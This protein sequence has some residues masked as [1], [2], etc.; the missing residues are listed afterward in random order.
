MKWNGVDVT[1]VGISA[2]GFRG[3]TESAPDV[4]LPMAAFPRL[5]G[6]SPHDVA[7]L[8]IA[9]IGRIAPGV[10]SR[11]AESQLD[12][13]VASL[14]PPPASDRQWQPARGVHLESAQASLPRSKR[15]VIAAAL[16]IVA[17]SMGLLLTLGCVNV[18]S[19]LLKLQSRGR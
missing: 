19:L 17:G 5:M 18:A 11:Q 4:W 3:T 15:A 16:A 8:P 6:A 13:A 7:A 1:I 10:T 12:A 2:Q 9:V 14:P